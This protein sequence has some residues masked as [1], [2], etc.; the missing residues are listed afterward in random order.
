[1]LLGANYYHYHRKES[2]GRKDKSL[3]TTHSGRDLDPG[4]SPGLSLLY[5]TEWPRGF[6]LFASKTEVTIAWRWNKNS[7]TTTDKTNS[8]GKKKGTKIDDRVL[9]GK[10]NTSS[11]E[12]KLN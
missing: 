11:M 8:Y 2:L 5:A 7:L 1:M 10:Y 9:S 6:Y 12:L 4:S 3:G